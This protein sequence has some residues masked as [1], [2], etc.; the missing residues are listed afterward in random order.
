MEDSRGAVISHLTKW[1]TITV[2]ALDELY[3]AKEALRAQGT[4]NDLTSGKNA[5]GWEAFCKEI[6]LERR[7]ADAWLSRWDP[8]TKT[9]REYVRVNEISLDPAL[10][11]TALRSGEL[12][13][14]AQVLG[15]TAKELE[16]FSVKVARVANKKKK[17]RA[18]QA[19]E[20]LSKQAKQADRPGPA[21][22]LMAFEVYQTALKKVHASLAAILKTYTPILKEYEKK[23]FTDE[24]A[25]IAEK[26]K[27]GCLVKLQSIRIDLHAKWEDFDKM[28]GEDI[29]KDLSRPTAPTDYTVPEDDTMP[30][31]NY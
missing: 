19:K 30:E 28:L 31:L 18:I 7:K 17:E 14:I 2:E 15:L 11:G 22:E 24:H 10:E 12:K 1:K 27:S 6:P 23:Q 13:E 8:V 3:R 25:A 16:E 29:E 5:G 26:I 20:A 9:V 21:D 4:R